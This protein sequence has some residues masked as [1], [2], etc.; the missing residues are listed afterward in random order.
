MSTVVDAFLYPSS[1]V[2][3]WR[4]F[5]TENRCYKHDKKQTR[6]RSIHNSDWYTWNTLGSGIKKKDR[7]RTWAYAGI[8]NS[9]K[10]KVLG[11]LLTHLVGD[12]N[13]KSSIE[14]VVDCQCL[15][16]KIRILA[17]CWLHHVFIRK[18]PPPYLL[19][20]NACIL[21]QVCVE[22]RLEDCRGLLCNQPQQK[23]H[24]TGDSCIGG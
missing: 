18:D 24:S 10:S 16:V 23:L 8:Q 14:C 20:L 5:Q 4:N 7:R 1:H 13:H 11:N 3:Y 6:T 2:H 21:K 12:N 15:F 9:K 17:F 19:D 22:M